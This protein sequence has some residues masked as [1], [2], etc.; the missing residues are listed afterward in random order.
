MNYFHYAFRTQLVGDMETLKQSSEK[1]NAKKN[2]Q[3]TIDGI[4]KLAEHAPEQSLA[5][6]D[7]D[8]NTP[9]H[10]AFNHNLCRLPSTKYVRRSAP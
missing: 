5:A 8:G 3:C 10:Y 2:L 7:S 9:I 1:A 6:K 4:F